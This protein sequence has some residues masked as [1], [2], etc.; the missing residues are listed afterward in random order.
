MENATSLCQKG[1]DHW[2]MVFRQWIR[3]WTQSQV[4]KLAEE[5][6]EGPR[7]I[8]S[9]Q[10]TNWRLGRLLEPAPKVVFAIGRFNQ[11]VAL[12]NGASITSNSQQPDS[13][14][15]VRFAG[16]SRRH[17]ENKRWLTYAGQPVGPVEVFLALC[18]QIQIDSLSPVVITAEEAPAL[19]HQ[20]ANL[21]RMQLAAA[22]RDW[23][24]ELE[25]FP[26]D[27]RTLLT[28]RQPLEAAELEL[29]TPALATVL[30]LPAEE[31][32]R[33]ARD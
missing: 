27:V 30:G 9:S 14:A 23:Y 4:L 19:T 5:I 10:L 11:A 18:G 29:L 32:I 20:L 17:W 8:H 26:T 13:C 31:L 22:G 15:V 2:S 16:N 12:S 28:T 21:A 25:Q 24:A 7:P 1:A 3:Q 6:F 33:Q